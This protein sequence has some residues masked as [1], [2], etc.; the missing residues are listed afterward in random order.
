MR[1]IFG[2][3]AMN[4]DKLIRLGVF[5]GEHAAAVSVVGDGWVGDATDQFFCGRSAQQVTFATI[6]T[7]YDGVWWAAHNYLSDE[8]YLFFLPALLAIAL[9]DYERPGAD[10]LADALSFGFLRMAQGDHD[11]RLLP[12]LSNYSKAQLGVISEFLK[13]L[14]SSRYAPQGGMDDAKSAYDLFWH[15]YATT[16]I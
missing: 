7:E 12:L 2:A 3:Y 14:S 11:D 5:S 8:A 15:Q 4:F 6:S 10:M 13:E 9:D 1:V 16:N